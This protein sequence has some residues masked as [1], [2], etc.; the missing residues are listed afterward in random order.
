MA[1]PFK[2][3]RKYQTWF[4][5]VLG[6]FL[7]FAF[8]IADPL[9]TLLGVSGRGAGGGTSGREVVVQW[10]GGAL[11]RRQLERRMQA[12]F[13]VEDLLQTLVQ[14]AFKQGGRNRTALLQT[15]R[16]ERELV[17]RMLLA[18][19]AK[20]LGMIVS[21]E[22]IYDYLDLISDRIYKTRDAYD[23]LLLRI[24]RS[25]GNRVRLGTG[26]ILNQ[27][28]T[29]LLAERYRIIAL[30]GV[31]SP[32]LGELWQ[33]HLKLRRQVVCD[34]FPFPRDDFVDQTGTPS[35]DAL[36]RLFAEGKD[37]YP[38][39]N[40][41]E[42]GFKIRRKAKF[43]YFVAEFDTF[44]DEEV[45]RLRDEVTDEEIKKYYET[46]KREFR[47]LE[48][49]P[50]S[51]KSSSSKEPPPSSTPDKKTPEKKT[52]DRKTPDK[53]QSKPD[54]SSSPDNPPAKKTLEKKTPAE[55]TPEKTTPD[56][57]TSDK[58]TK[59][60]ANGRKTPGGEKSSRLETPGAPHV[61]AAVP[62][63][64][65]SDGQAAPGN[66]K[67]K[68]K[69]AAPGRAADT[70]AGNTKQPAKQKATKKESA[71][72]KSPR[73]EANKK[74]PDKKTADKKQPGGKPSDKADEAGKADDKGGAKET[75]PVRYR[76]LDDK[77]KEEIRDRVAREKAQPIAGRKV[78]R[79]ISA[80]RRA[81]T[82]YQR[83]VGLAERRRQ[84]VPAP[85]DF[86][87]LAKKYGL[88]YH[89]TRLVD[90]LEIQR[91]ATAPAAELP[92]EAPDLFRAREFRFQPQFTQVSFVDMAAEILLGPRENVAP[93]RPELISHGPS[94][95]PELRFTPSKVFIFWVASFEPER[96][97][98]FDEAREAVVT[99][100]KAGEAF[101]LAEKA[102]REL[103]ERANS[104]DKPLAQVLDESQRPRLVTTLPFSWLTQG[105]VGMG[106]SARVSD[107]TGT[108]PDGK[109]VTF[110][111]LGD[112][113]MEAVFKLKPGR[114][115]ATHD[116][117]RQHAFAVQLKRDAK[118]P[119][120]VRELFLVSDVHQRLMS[121]TVP[122]RSRMVQTWYNQLAKEYELKWIAP[123]SGR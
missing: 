75:E 60:P 2:F 118:S 61:P 30:G 74:Q 6:V 120:Q 14:Q 5:V 103:V 71:N 1:S 85:P 101:K 95:T 48:L 70:G 88:A 86:R 58:K 87:A 97:P 121:L 72:E 56:K 17:M 82:E 18:E 108:T 38:D 80:A 8:V 115:D 40:A 59:P 123:T 84:P 113:F 9:M 23:A 37:R 52:P 49:P 7:M 65:Q 93:Y 119:E 79:A 39:P 90:I 22:A 62:V 55:K 20:A 47:E 116:Y 102:A 13:A 81:L 98:T 19:R 105:P 91:L 114:V 83:S 36:R 122:E 41:P 73:K 11:T 76:P 117:P 112:S 107:V 32:S 77:L 64:F 109:T 57:K 92:K 27:L 51:D 68:A 100:W 94:L 106:Q 15:A 35:D 99:A 10:K 45:K 4:Y 29:D 63:S 26:E 50:A 46:N 66:A 21:D 69:Q 43:G 33:L 104:A 96:V 89:E 34:I 42:P 25:Q 16:D 111:R 53:P 78:R 110:E 67:T 31:L 54:G 44:L 28:R 3:F 12:E 24:V